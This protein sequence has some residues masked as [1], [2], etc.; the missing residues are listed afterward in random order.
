MGKNELH[1]E[2]T[3]TRVTATL[4]ITKATDLDEIITRIENV[5]NGQAV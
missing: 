2:S 1:Q 4:D 5:T 3:S